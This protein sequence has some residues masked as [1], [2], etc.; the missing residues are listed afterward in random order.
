MKDKA[1]WMSCHMRQCVCV[2]LYN[3][4]VKQ[5]RHIR[6]TCSVMSDPIYVDLT[7]LCSLMFTPRRLH[8]ILCATVL[9]EQLPYCRSGVN[10]DN[11]RCVEIQL[12]ELMPFLKTQAETDKR[13]TALVQHFESMN[14]SVLCKAL[15]K[16]RNGEFASLQKKRVE[17]RH[18]LQLLQREFLERLRDTERRAGSDIFHQVWPGAR[19]VIQEL[20]T[21]APE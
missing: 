3:F 20:T 16:R 1:W 2:T 6:L 12:E 15:Y 21:V 11:H 18:K 4:R 10:V 17:L 5:W 13:E 19:A 14:F 7:K 9:P 8:Q